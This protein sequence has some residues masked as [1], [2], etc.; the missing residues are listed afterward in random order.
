MPEEEIEPSLVKTLDE[1]ELE[2][3]T[4]KVELLKG[5]LQKLEEAK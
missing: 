2:L 4:Q 3:L 1:L 5:R